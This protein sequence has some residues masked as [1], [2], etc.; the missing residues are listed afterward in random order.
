MKAQL[1]LIGIELGSK[2]LTS[3]KR[4]SIASR[5]RATSS[6]A[7]SILRSPRQARK[8]GFRTWATAFNPHVW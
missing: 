3:T 8:A 2:R 4:L 5:R 1:L 7:S 6:P